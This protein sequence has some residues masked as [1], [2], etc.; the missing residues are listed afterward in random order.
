[1]RE[2]CSITRADGA[3]IERAQRAIARH[4]A[5]QP[6]VE[7]H[8]F[9]RAVHRLLEIDGD[10]EQVLEIGIVLRQEVI[11]HALAEQHDLDVERNGLRLERHGGEHAVDLVGHVDAQLARFQ[12]ALQFFPGEGRQQHLARFHDEIAAVGAMQRAR[13][14]QRVVGDQRA[15]LR[16]MLDAAEQALQIRIVFIDDRRALAFAVVDHQIDLIAAQCRHRRR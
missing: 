11:E 2:A 15:V 4:V 8:G 16:D 13:L 3:G 9:R 7:L 12:R 1:M 5:D 10:L 6:G 14:D